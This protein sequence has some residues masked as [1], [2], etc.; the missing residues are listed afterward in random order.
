MG[1]YAIYTREPFSSPF[2]RALMEAIEVVD[3]DGYMQTLAMVLDRMMHIK[4]VIEPLLSSGYIVVCDRYTPS[5]IAYQGALG[6][7]IEWILEV[8]RHV[9]E[10]DLVILLD[11]DL[12]TALRRI[13]GYRSSRRWRIFEDVDVLKR[14][15]EIY[16]K[17]PQILRWRIAVVD[18]TKPI[19]QVVDECLKYIISSLAS[20]DSEELS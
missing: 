4:S 13:G 18:A 8:S 2:S 3:V 5:T 20:S 7:D 9:L 15:I 11:I 19:E 12:D 16:R 1:I 17:L 6:A 10:P 14:A